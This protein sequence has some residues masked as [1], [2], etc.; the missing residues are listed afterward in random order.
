[1]R[2]TIIL[3]LIL[4]S[5]QQPTQNTEKQ[6]QPLS[7]SRLIGRYE[8]KDQWEDPKSPEE[9]LYQKRYTFD[10]T[11][12]R[13]RFFMYLEWRYE[14]GWKYTG[15]VPGDYETWFEEIQIK[16]ENGRTFI[17]ERLWDKTE[18]QDWWGWQEYTFSEDNTILT[19]GEFPYTKQ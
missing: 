5:C 2:K 6:P 9:F 13:Y 10:G 3:L 4:A 14:F 19:I 16:E 11:S 1:M 17:R 18:D 8:Y 7:D 12:K 15:K